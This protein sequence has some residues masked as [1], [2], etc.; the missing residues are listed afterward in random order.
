MSQCECEC[1]K[2]CVVSV[3]SAV[4]VQ[5]LMCILCTHVHVSAIRDMV[6]AQWLRLRV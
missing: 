4:R 5:L 3:V 6:N 2:C 1:C